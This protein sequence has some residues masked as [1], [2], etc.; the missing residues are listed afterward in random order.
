MGEYPA[1]YFATANKEV[2]KAAQI[3][4]GRTRS[5]KRKYAAQLREMKKRGDTNEQ[6]AWFCQRLEDPEASILHIQKLVDKFLLEQP[7]DVNRL[8]GY[9]TLIKLHKA[10]FGE[11]H[12][13]ININMDVDIDVE[14]VK[15]HLDKLFGGQ[16]N[17]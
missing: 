13:N 4:G 17:E 14:K 7:E 16:E 8:K 3:K 12:K 6:V 9:D 1:K 10:H 5:I 11:K 15:E 2:L